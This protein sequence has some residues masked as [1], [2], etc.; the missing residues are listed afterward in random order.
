MRIWSILLGAWLIL[1][2]LE[3]LINLHFRYDD[4]VSSALALLAGI[5]VLIRK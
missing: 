5:F 4:V 2:G 1:H 3:E